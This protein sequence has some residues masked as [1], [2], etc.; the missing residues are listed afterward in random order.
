MPVKRPK[1]GRKAPPRFVAAITGATGAAIGI[2]L[3]AEMLKTAEVHLIISKSAFSIIEYETGN[4][5]RDDPIGQL[6]DYYKSS[7]IYYHC[8]DDLQ[9]QLSSGSFRTDGMAIVP[10][11]MKTLSAIANGYAA[12]LTARAADVTIKEGR[13]LLLSPREMPFSAIHLENMLKLAR[14]GVAIAPPVPGFYHKPET[15]SDAVDFIA[16]KILD[17]LG[18][19]H[20]LFMRWDGPISD[21]P[22][23]NHT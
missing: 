11:S 14:L 3:V 10:C 2:R 8:E 15:L 20:S 21:T 9:S 4:A 19:Q 12:N 23:T 6:R 16:G 7:R 18:I 1:S 22:W 13:K 5:W 17:Q